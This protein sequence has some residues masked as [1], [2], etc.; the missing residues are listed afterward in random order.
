MKS[1]FYIL[2]FLVPMLIAGCIKTYHNPDTDPRNNNY[3]L[4]TFTGKFMRVHIDPQTRKTDTIKT[5]IQLMLSTNTGFYV[6]GD[7]SVF[8]A[9][10][11]G[12]FS[13]DY[14]DMSMSFHDVTWPAHVYDHKT[15]LMGSYKYSYNGS[16]LAIVDNK[17]SDTLQYIYHL[18]K[19]Y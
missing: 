11:Y 4:G 2:L 13:E 5:D 7:T 6:S 17:A 8:H 19:K 10:S 14:T 18:N 16:Y 3:P 12:S 9:G 15:H 1:K